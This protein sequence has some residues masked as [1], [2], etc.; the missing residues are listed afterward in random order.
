MER[1]AV[2]FKEEKMVGGTSATVVFSMWM[3]SS[4]IGMVGAWAWSVSQHL[5]RWC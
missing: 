1:P 5:H 4:H 2:D 3:R